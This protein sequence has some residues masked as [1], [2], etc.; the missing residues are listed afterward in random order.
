[1]EGYSIRLGV[2]RESFCEEMIDMIT[3]KMRKS[4]QCKELQAKNILVQCC[5]KRTFCDDGNAICLCC[6]VEHS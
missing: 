4:Q 2:I 5:S 3:L 6:D 1:M